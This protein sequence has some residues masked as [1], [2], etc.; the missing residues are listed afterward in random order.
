MGIFESI[1]DFLYPP[2]CPK[3]RAYVKAR[4][5]WCVECLQETSQIHRLPLSVEAAG[6]LAAVWA[7]GRYRGGLQDLIRG[8]KYHGKKGNLPCIRTFLK[9]CDRV[10][11]DVPASVVAVP[12]PLHSLREKQRGF[13]QAELMF[14]DWLAERG[15]PM[16]RML[17]RRRE[18]A[19]QYGLTAEERRENVQGAFSLAEGICVTGRD[20]LLVDDIMT[21]G[22]TLSACAEVLRRGGAARVYG[23]VLASDRA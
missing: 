7:L 20:I 17:L 16:E 5:D 1:L 13:N 11:A 4:G 2:R 9:S 10:L 3:C 12:V 19:A 18:T 22:A 21:T 6:S 15:I 8:L 23:L 14:R